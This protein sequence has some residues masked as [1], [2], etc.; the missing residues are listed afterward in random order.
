MIFFEQ[1][2]CPLRFIRVLSRAIPPVSGTD[3]QGG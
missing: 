3:L 2:G 1:T